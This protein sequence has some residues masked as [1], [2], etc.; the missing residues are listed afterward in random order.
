MAVGALNNGLHGRPITV[1]AVN[2]TVPIYVHHCYPQDQRS[3][4][5]EVYLA[6][7][8]TESSA[9]RIEVL[10]NDGIS[11]IT[12]AA[13]DTKMVFL[14]VRG[15]DSNF[16]PAGQAS[17]GVRWAVGFSGTI[18]VTGGWRDGKNL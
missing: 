2:P 8:N 14:T 6:I 16:T 13:N 4:T 9:G 5:F 12:I 18:R 3:Q 15:A 17:V 7:S 1:T 10:Y 11:E